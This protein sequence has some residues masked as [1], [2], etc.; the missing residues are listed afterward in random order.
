MSRCDLRNS[1][2]NVSLCVSGCWLI[3]VLELPS[4]NAFYKISWWLLTFF[5]SPIITSTNQECYLLQMGSEN[6]SSHMD[7]QADL[8]VVHQSFFHDKH[9]PNTSGCGCDLVDFI[10]CKEVMQC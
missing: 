3:V 10:P 5:G 1:F 7:T 9:W 2:K 8:V 6:E 4:K